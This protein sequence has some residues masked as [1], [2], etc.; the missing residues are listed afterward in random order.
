MEFFDNDI[1]DILQHIAV[2]LEISAGVLILYDLKQHQKDR[3]LSSLR[4]ASRG[5]TSGIKD[6]SNWFY[7]GIFLAFIAILMELYQLGCI[8]FA[9]PD[10]CPTCGATDRLSI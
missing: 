6:R 2:F 5:Y 7:I 4:I 9:I 10:T 3:G 8:Y 1:A